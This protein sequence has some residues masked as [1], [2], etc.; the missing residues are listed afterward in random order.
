[1]NQVAIVTGGTSGIG[2]AAAKA[3]QRAG[4]VVYTFSRR[5]GGDDQIRNLSVDV[6]NEDFVAGAVSRIREQE[7]R[8]D[9]VVNCAGFGISGAIEFTN[10]ADAKRLMDTD[11]FG[12]VNVNKAVIPIM[13]AQTPAKAGKVREAGR[14][15]N[16]SSVAGPAAIPFQAFYS[17]AKAAIDAYS[18]ALA[19]ELKPFHITVTTIR[20]GDVQTG[21]TGARE[22]KHE[23]NDIYGGRIDKS[24]AKMEKDEKNGM[25]PDVLGRYILKIARTPNPKPFY[26]PGFV[27][28]A[29]IFLIRHLPCRLVNDLIGMLYVVK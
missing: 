12:T 29:C 6:T 28:K 24:V 25:S 16:I 19:N 15:I 7:G 21:F 26:T 10:T 23:G 4:Y 9:L 8:I 22:K 13:R 14:I 3:L 11:F 5:G 27:Y 17:S 20:P 18:A 1:M 2:L